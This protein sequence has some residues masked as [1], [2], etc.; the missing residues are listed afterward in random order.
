MT[1]SDFAREAA[2]AVETVRPAFGL[3]IGQQYPTLER[4]LRPIFDRCSAEARRE[5][6]EE[7]AIWILENI[8]PHDTRSDCVAAIRALAEQETPNG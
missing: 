7:A 5:A 2:E 1:P 8:N 4:V 6:L 3:T